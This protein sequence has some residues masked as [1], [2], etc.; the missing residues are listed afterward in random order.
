MTSPVEKTSPIPGPVCI[1]GIGGGGTR[2]FADFLSRCGYYIG[3]DLNDALDN[4]WF[5][6]LFK[7]PSVLVETP[8]AIGN[9]IDGFVEKMTT[10]R[11]PQGLAAKAAQLARRD[12][13]QHSISWLAARATSLLA[14]HEVAAGHPIGWKEPNTHVIADQLLARVTGLRY[15]HVVRN[16]FDMIFSGNINQH[17]LWG[18]TFLDIAGEPTLS[19]R[20]R[21][22]CLVQ[23]RIEELQSEFEGRVLIVKYEEMINDT[24]N[25]ASA[26]G[27][28]LG[29]KLPDRMLYDYAA[30][31]RAEGT[32][33]R[34]Q[35]HDLSILLEDDIR[36]AA[37]RGYV[38]GAA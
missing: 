35:G 28:S 32:T 19:R 17:L 20:L 26:L 5:T 16:P 34:W 21:Y 27:R 13:A 37:I 15:V 14:P 9:L 23:S 38:V 6:L 30:S 8:G 1:G 2:I 24:V 22:W 29:V 7:R 3:S 18:S 12:D 4:L 25:C 33:G 11:F 31:L 36:F 10:G